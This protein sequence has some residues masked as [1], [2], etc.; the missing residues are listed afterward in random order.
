MIK[1][2]YT[3]PIPPRLSIC[4]SLQK[5]RVLSY[6]QGVYEIPDVKSLVRQTGHIFL[7]GDRITKRGSHNLATVLNHEKFIAV[8]N[9]VVEKIDLVMVNCMTK[10]S[11]ILYTQSKIFKFRRWFY[12]VEHCCTSVLD[13]SRPFPLGRL[14]L[15]A[16]K[17]TTLDGH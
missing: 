3:K 5:S 16:G 2:D 12:S 17:Q 1:Q 7:S 9:A 10:V 8:F 4:S 13:D 15:L 11:V 6:N 14:V